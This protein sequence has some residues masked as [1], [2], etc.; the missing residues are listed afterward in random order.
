MKPPAKKKPPRN[1]AW[2]AG[3]LGVSQQRVSELIHEESWRW[4]QKNW[5]DQELTEIREEL[6]RRRGENNATADL[7][8]SED[9][10]DL[11]RAL[12]RDPLK[13]AKLKKL[14]KETALIELNTGL[15]RGDFL[16]RAEVEAERLT[17]IEAVKLKMGQLPLRANLIANKPEDECE[18]ILMQWM[19][20]ICNAFARAA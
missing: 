19:K 2:L 14:I 9:G 1:Q 6:N 5:T 20:E 17:R 7:E 8:D 13:L 12:K 10:R 3:K 11:A 4:G 16:P 18:K 15:K